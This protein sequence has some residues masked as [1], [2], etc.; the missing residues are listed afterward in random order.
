MQ[1]KVL[2]PKTRGARLC[3]PV[4]AH[5]GVLGSE[6][7]PEAAEQ[8]THLV[9]SPAI[10]VLYK[11]QL[12]WGFHLC[13]NSFLGIMCCFFFLWYY[14]N[15]KQ[16][17]EPCLKEIMIDFGVA[18]SHKETKELAV[19]SQGC[20]C[21]SDSSSSKRTAVLSLQCL[22]SLFLGKKGCCSLMA[23]FS[24]YQMKQ[25]KLLD[26]VSQPGVNTWMAGLTLICEDH[27][28]PVFAFLKRPTN[29]Q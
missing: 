1:E 26:F 23:I 17:S 16:S 18:A 21:I 20:P 12:Q 2:F 29:F 27:C 5:P 19:Q 10:Q 9:D 22:A 3:V 7:G 15:T 28:S 25:L 8:D 6:L 11:S 4:P 24:P 13:R 14:E